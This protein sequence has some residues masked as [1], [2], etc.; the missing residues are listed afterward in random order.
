MQRNYWEQPERMLEFLV[1]DYLRHVKQH[2]NQI[3][4]AAS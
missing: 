2:L 3:Q 4:P 1:K